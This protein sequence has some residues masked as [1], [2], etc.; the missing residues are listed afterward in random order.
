MT[1]TISCLF[2]LSCKTICLERPSRNQFRKVASFLQGWAVTIYP[3]LRSKFG[4]GKYKEKT[5]NG[6]AIQSFDTLRPRQNGRHFAGDIFKRIF[7]SENCRIL[8]K[9]SLKFVPHGLINNSSALVQIMARHRLG[10]K[11]LAG[12]KPLS[13]PMMVS[14]LTHICVT[15]PQWVNNLP[16]IVLPAMCAKGISHYIYMYI[17]ISS[18][19]NIWNVNCARATAFVFDSRTDVLVKVSNWE[20]LEPPTSRFHS[21]ATWAI[22]VRH[23]LSH[24]LEYWLWW[25]RYFCSKVNI[26]N[27]NY[28][29]I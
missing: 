1:Y 23:L 22:R 5:N 16:F 20:G 24:V 10:D 17:Y 29:F 21:L 28:A 12:D 11:P 15:R 26:W 6:T 8:I 18:K 4:G 9:I 25:Y 27:V 7:L 13:E 19:V 2:F 3:G 14:L